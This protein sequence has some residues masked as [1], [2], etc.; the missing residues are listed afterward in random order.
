M[1]ILLTIFTFVRFVLQNPV[2]AYYLTP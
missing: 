2:Q 1:I